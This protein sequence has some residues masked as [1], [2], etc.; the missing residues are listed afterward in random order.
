MIGERLKKIRKEKSLS[1][2]ELAKLI[3]TSQGYICDIEQGIKMPGS[4]FLI[5]L[6]RVLE[7][8]LNWLLIGEVPAPERKTVDH[9]IQ[10]VVSIMERL[11][12]KAKADIVRVAEKEEL[13]SDVKKMRGLKPIGEGG[14]IAVNL[15]IQLLLPVELILIAV[16]YGLISGELA[17]EA[18][19]WAGYFI[20][21]AL[22]AAVVY[23]VQAVRWLKLRF[24][25]V[26]IFNS[27]RFGLW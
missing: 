24:C 16:G 19:T 3:G 17:W 1:Q 18:L 9:Q 11:D 14:I 7:I 25:S 5:S 27:P 8:D 6:K 26:V 21:F 23:P 15:L 4:D 20:C 2:K 10:E 12:D 22:P 13:I